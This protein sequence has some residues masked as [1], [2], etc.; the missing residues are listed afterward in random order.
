[1][2]PENYKVTGGSVI[3]EAQSTQDFRITSTAPFWNFEL[4]NSSA[5][6]R[7]FTL[8]EAQNIGPV[9]INIPAQPLKVLNDL[10][11]WGTESGGDSYPAITFIPGINDVYIGG[12]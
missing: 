10:R 4:R 5:A 6:D 9:N 7:Q 1:S 11:I 2:A 3:V 8:S 12:S